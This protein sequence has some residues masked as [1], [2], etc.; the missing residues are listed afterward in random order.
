MKKRFKLIS[1]TVLAIFAFNIGCTDLE[2]ENLNDPDTVR[3]LSNPDDLLNLA[4]EAMCT[5]YRRT[6]EYSGPALDLATT[7][8][9][10]TSSF[11]GMAYLSYEPRRTW[12]NSPEFSYFFR[13]KHLWNDY[14]T[15]LSD[16]AD[17]LKMIK[18]GAQ[19]GYNGKDNNMVMAWCCMMQGIY[20]GYLGLLFDKAKILDEDTDLAKM[21]YSK[22]NVVISA[23]VDK[24]DK[25]IKICEDNTFEIPDGW[26]NGL[27]Y[28]NERLSRLANTFTGRFIA[29]SP[30]NASYAEKNIDW[31]K[32]ENYLSKGI[33]DD[34]APVM[35]DLTWWNKL[36]T[37]IAR[38]DWS[39]IDMR[40]INMLAPSQP[41]YYPLSGNSSD[42]P[43]YGEVLEGESDD[44]RMYID[45]EYN[46]SCPY[47]ASR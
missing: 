6:H 34:F 39:R 40:V 7:S 11:C 38:S 8:D 12:I 2:I 10:R 41:D 43:N 42:L 18:N 4:G 45:F 28:D 32:V 5:C 15:S 14:Y 22:W 30:R 21:E 20:L 26:I 44:A 35:D 29:Y 31:V 13:I 17:V 46:I 1:L 25:A 19:I 3:V 23:A 16:L 27:N 24:L 9:V 36:I 47:P 33:T 37:Y